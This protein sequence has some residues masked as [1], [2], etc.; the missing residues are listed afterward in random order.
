MTRLQANAGLTCHFD[1]DWGFKVC[2]DEN[3]C[4]LGAKPNDMVLVEEPYLQN[5]ILDADIMGSFCPS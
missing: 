1:N 4:L 2:Y 3:G 5:D